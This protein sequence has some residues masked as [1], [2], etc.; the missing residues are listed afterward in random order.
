MSILQTLRDIRR[1]RQITNILFKQGLGYFIEKAQLKGYLAF[2]RR[3]LVEK[4]EKP[5]AIPVRLR[6]AMEE[7]QGSFVK[8]GQ[9]LSIRPDLIPNEYCEEFSKLQDHVKPFPF[10]VAKKILK[11]EFKKPLSEIFQSIDPLPLA[12]ASVGQ[13]HKAV[14][15]TGEVVA[16]KIQRP[17][18]RAIFNTDIDL[19]YHLAGVVENYIPEIK[20]YNI[21]GIVKEFDSYTNDELDYMVE[22]QNIDIF[23][24]KFLNDPIVKVPKVYWD[25][26]TSRVL[27][28][29]FINGPKLKDVKTDKDFNA[30]LSN[31]KAVIANINNALAR[32]IL[33]FKYFHADPHPGNI[34]VLRNNKIALLDFGII[35]RITE[36]MQE[37]MEDL[38]IALLKKDPHLLADTLVDVGVVSDD[39]DLGAF[40]EDMVAHFEKYYE[41]TLEQINPQTVFYDAFNMGRKYNV[42][43]PLNFV[44]LAKALA[45]IYGVNRQY[46]PDYNFVEG[47]RPIV[48]NVIRKRSSPS[49]LAD[50]MK[51]NIYE[52]RRAFKRIPT[53]AKGI[54]NL[55]KRGA[56]VQIE[57][58]NKD[59]KRFTREMDR[60]SNRLTFGLIIS[61][62]VVA[63][64]LSIGTGLEPYLWGI[65]KIGVV[66]LLLA[67]LFT[68]AMFY[69][70]SREPKGGESE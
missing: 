35:G 40:E 18:I 19:L 30:R 15:K 47:V 17:N 29:E 65:P 57:V 27:T 62:L 4:F 25:Y 52:L 34:L 49:Y 24:K 3:V 20:N 54:I 13:V 38:L 1:L 41:M 69:S 39:I 28:M 9:L 16:V 48:E 66:T 67:A 56:H 8:L 22:A 44:L 5:E 68:F 26:T 37:K 58:D 31:R 2:R 14:L 11:D 42:V 23:Y 36:D 50:T 63:T 70:I 7:L 21:V 60:S 46:Y 64:F 53:N 33:E 61:A 32:Q 43:F 51:K 6:K 55:I 45:T 12:S 10:D 59:L